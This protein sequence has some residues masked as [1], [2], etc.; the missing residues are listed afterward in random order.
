MTTCWSCGHGETK[1][2]LK[3]IYNKW[4]TASSQSSKKWDV[5]KGWIKLNNDDTCK[6]CGRLFRNSKGRWWKG[7]I[8]S[9]I[10]K[11]IRKY[12]SY[13]FKLIGIYRPKIPFFRYN[14]IYIAK[15]TSKTKCM[16]RF[17]FHSFGF[18]GYVYEPMLSVTLQE[19]YKFI[20]I[21]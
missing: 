16:S 18:G 3:R 8:K 20:T 10:I 5:N 6:G 7:W 2:F 13:F 9:K 12:N 21:K 11:V 17:F 15:Y 1:R 4:S 19:H 14:L